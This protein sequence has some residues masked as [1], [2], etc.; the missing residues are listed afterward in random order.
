MELEEF[1]QYLVDL[2][3]D[4]PRCSPGTPETTKKAFL[5]LDALPKM[6]KILDI[7]CGTGMQTIELAKLSKGTIIA[8]DICE[9]FLDVLNK[10]AEKEGVS[11]QIE[12]F[13]TSMFSLDFAE[14]SFDVIWAEGSIYFYGFEKGLINWQKFLKKGGYFVV[15]ELEWFKNDPPNELKEYWTVAFPEISNNESHLR[16]IKKT[17]YKLVGQF[18]FSSNDWLPMYSSLERKIQ[19]LREIYKENNEALKEYDE[20]QKE[21]EIFKKYNMFFGYMIYVLQT[22]KK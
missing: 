21:I 5:M 3:K 18:P 19:E 20:N 17:G 4:L 22:R 14:E 12:T 9:P 16:I 6:P 13:H 1:P 15:S 8:I 7:G 11:H 2:Y 10:R